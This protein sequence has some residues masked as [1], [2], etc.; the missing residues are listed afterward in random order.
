MIIPHDL[1]V[2]N[3]ILLRGALMFALIDMVFV[4]VLYK[5]IKRACLIRMKWNL[6]IIM[7][8]FFTVLMGSIMSF[9]FWDSVY[10]YVYP[11]QA[12]WIIPFCYGLL[13]SAAGLLFWR[14]SIRAVKYSV[15]IFCLFGGLWGILT[16]IL[17]IRRGILEKPPMLTG[18]SPFAAL[19]IA[20]F[21][22]I[23]YWCVCLTISG[24]LTS[25]RTEKSDHADIAGSEK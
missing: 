25:K 13:F 2:T 18:S 20:A 15:V 3:E 24:L 11:D 12:R 14:I 10:S 5:F 23:F 1:K 6:V 7:V 9:I 8:L 16:H 19:T 21:E 4:A 17:A 22:F